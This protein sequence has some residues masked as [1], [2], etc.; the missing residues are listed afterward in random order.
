MGIEVDLR[1][2]ESVEEHLRRLKDNH[3]KTKSEEKDFFDL[4]RLSNPYSDTRIIFGGDDKKVKRIMAGIDVDAGELMVAKYISEHGEKPI[5]L[6]ISHHPTGKALAGLDEV[7]HLQ[8]EVLALYGVPINV[9]QSLLK[10]RI[11]EVARGIAPINHNKA[12]MAAKN[13][14]LALMCVHTPTDNLVASFLKKTIEEAKPKYV[15]DL[16]ELLKK[17]PEYKEAE[18]D[19]A[20]VKLFSGDKDNYCGK[21]ALTEITGGTEGSAKIYEK[22]A[23]AG[24]GTV[25]GMHVS[26]EHKKEAEASHLNVVIAGHISSDSLGF[27]LF[28]D[29]LEKNGIEI[30]PASGLIR[31]RRWN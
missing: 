18:K 6:F 4:E 15:K 23:I 26:E 11:G 16:I 24:I 17:F 30:I 25:V 12:A 27:N 28:L 22:M 5:D 1:G 13:L 2:R 7:M 10:P 31:I 14:N 20:G 3:K 19:K 8:A 9:A 29:E 21:I